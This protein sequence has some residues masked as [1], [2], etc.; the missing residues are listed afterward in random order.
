MHQSQFLADHHIS[1]ETLPHAPAFTAQRRAKYLGLSGRQVAKTVLLRGPAGYLLAVLPAT[2]QVDREALERHLGG[3]V[4][5]ATREEVADVFLD[6]EWGVASPLG[7]IYGLPTFLDASLAADAAIVLE[8][9]SHF[10]AV[11]LRCADFERVA[12]PTRLP[13]AK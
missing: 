2:A 5:V 3:P 8:L 11:R 12:A 13:L 4:R 6:C 1:F 10:E 9:Q 7:T